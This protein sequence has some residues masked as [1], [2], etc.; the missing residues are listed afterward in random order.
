MTTKATILRTIREHCLECLGGSWSEVEKCSA[1]RCSLHP[2]RF[3]TDPT[4]N[5]AKAE[6]MRCRNMLNARV[7]GE[8]E[9]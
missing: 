3:G 2:Y 5:A 6:N 1:P 8:D 9:T 7:G 4:P